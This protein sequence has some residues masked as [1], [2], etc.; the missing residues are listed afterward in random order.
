MP[1]HGLPRRIS[2]DDPE[3]GEKLM[4]DGCGSLRQLQGE[5]RRS[6]TF[7]FFFFFFHPPGTRFFCSPLG[8][9]NPHK[10]F[11]TRKTKK[12]A[13]T[14]KARRE[15]SPKRALWLNSG[16]RY[17]GGRI[18]IWGEAPWAFSGRTPK[19]KPTLAFGKRRLSRGQA[20]F[21]QCAIAFARSAERKLC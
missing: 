7:F 13:F 16:H 2:N 6:R 21:R 3:L 15:R 14:E 12:M 4:N 19:N 10:A 17:E 1:P 11:G 8:G 9:G 20:A 5:T 18:A